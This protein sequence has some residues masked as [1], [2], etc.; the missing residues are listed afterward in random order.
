MR[1]VFRPA[2]RKVPLDQ[3]AGMDPAQIYHEL[4]EHRWYLSEKAQHDVGLDAT[5]E[6]YLTDALPHSADLTAAS[7]PPPATA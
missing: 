2:V 6:S 1:D 5:V 7:V 3:R 4:L